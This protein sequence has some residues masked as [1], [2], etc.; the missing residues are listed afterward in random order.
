MGY[1]V[2]GAA[3]S[4]SGTYNPVIYSNKLLLKFYLMTV[5]GAIANT[6][7]EGEIKGFGD[8]VEIRKIPDMVVRDYVK[9]QDLI[10][11]DPE[12]DTVSLNID[13]GK[14]FGIRAFD[15]DRAQAD[16]NYVD[17]WAKDG[18]EQMKIAIDAS[19]LS[20]LPSKAHAEN[21]G[22]TAG[23]QA[24]NLNLGAAGSPVAI[25]K[26]NVIDLIVYADQVLSEQSIPESDRWMVI[27]SWMK[28]NVLLSELKDASLSG[29]ETS[30][31]RNGRMGKI[32][33]FTLY[34]SQ[35]VK[36]VVDSTHNC[37]SV[38]FGHKSC[39]TFASQIVKNE[40][41]RNPKDF[42]DL[43]RGLQ[44]YGWEVIKSR[45]LGFI[46]GYGSN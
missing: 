34:E 43:I 26:A 45:G 4:H 5:F 44:V 20:T 28:T 39:L 23:K 16:I 22:A 29:D 46:Y 41:L 33:N 10:Y 40:D 13:K 25:T 21:I 38:P 31:L 1:P 12:P 24:N 30:T 19:I 42:G 17:E 32:G 7:Y 15:I 27:P 35:N 6:D 37:A 14:Y 8:T 18:A 36:H 2:G 9:G 3:K 11:D